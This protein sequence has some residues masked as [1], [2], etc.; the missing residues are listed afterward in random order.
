M[1][2][3]ERFLLGRSGPKILLLVCMVFVALAW[4]PCLVAQPISIEL[5][6]KGLASLE[7]I[8]ITP[9]GNSYQVLRAVRGEQILADGSAKASRGNLAAGIVGT[10]TITRLLP[11]RYSFFVNDLAGSDE[12]PGEMTWSSDSATV[13]IRRGNTTE[14][15]KPAA[16]R[17]GKSARGR[18][19]HAFDIDG[20][21]GETGIVNLV[22]PYRKMVYGYIADAVTGRGVAG[23]K[24]SLHDERGNVVDEMNTE[25]GGLYMAFPPG[26]G[27]WKVRF[28]KEGLI[29]T[30]RTVR[31]LIAES[32]IRFDI[33]VSERLKADQIR[34]V[35]SWGR[36]PQDLDSHL[37]G[38]A[39]NDEEFHIS[40]RQMK[41]YGGRYFLDRDDQDSYGPET[42][43]LNKPEQGEFLFSVHD[44]SNIEKP[45]SGA[46]SAS[47]AL[48]TVYKGSAVVT[49]F[50]VPSGK[51][52]WWHVLRFNEFGEVTA[53]DRIDDNPLP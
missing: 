10:W 37:S 53:I 21:S 44:Y 50:N 34:I 46:L 49:S 11:G 28:N 32:P 47:G 40:Y 45:K 2:L 27:T 4:A 33:A 26:P 24:V 25:A 13:V 15:I 9:D 43:T 52:T 5:R 36:Y 38:P 16:L 35:L 31:Y 20:S 1:N 30:E 39:E 14:E 42:V 18:T 17:N 22:F 51:G 19:W 8:L 23:V 3:K 12:A 6:G 41:E 48:V 7:G 29:A